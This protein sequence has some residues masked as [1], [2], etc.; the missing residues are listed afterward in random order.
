MT[1][2]WRM[3]L[4]PFGKGEWA[5]ETDCEL[6]LSARSARLALAGERELASLVTAADGLTSTAT[7]AQCISRSTLPLCALCVCTARGLSRARSGLLTQS[8]LT[9]HTLL[10]D[11][12]FGW[13]GGQTVK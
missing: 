2:D 3:L 4:R 12:P 10:V 7:R 1:H 13:K 8:A 6:M 5:S 11:S 9:R